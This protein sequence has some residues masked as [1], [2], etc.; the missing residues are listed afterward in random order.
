MAGQVVPASD[1]HY[2]EDRTALVSALKSQR[3]DVTSVYH[4]FNPYPWRLTADD[5]SQMKVLL[6]T[7]VRAMTATVQNYFQDPRLRQIMPLSD[8]AQSL[9]RLADK[10][11]YRTGGIRPDFLHATDGAIRI[12]E[13]NARFPLNG[14]FLSHAFDAAIRTAPY[15]RRF[16]IRWQGIPALAEVPE[17]L[18]EVIGSNRRLA[19]VKGQEHGYDM[20]L[21]LEFWTNSIELLPEGASSLAPV[22]DFVVM[23]LHQ[24]E[25][26]QKLPRDALQAMIDNGRYFNDVRT[27]L[28]GHDKRLLA[29]FTSD[30]LRDYLP[31]EDV[32]RLHRHVVCTYVVGLGGDPLRAALDKQNE[33]LVKPNLFGKGQ[34][35]V[36]GRN[37]SQQAWR[38]ELD[39][40]PAEYVLQPFVEQQKFNILTEVGDDLRSV[41]M[42]VVGLLPALN[43]HVLGPGIYRASLEDIVNVAGGGAILAPVIASNL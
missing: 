39:S 4:A 42:N 30:I 1:S 7:V 35:I 22:S 25:L 32:E 8:E 27:I 14:F 34:G 38:S 40:A 5:V 18:T 10:Y 23:E 31:S 12:N 36:I 16:P 11:P 9:L 19:V 3:P 33:W 15:Q 17:A 21:L 6:Q 28:V 43:E 26:L 24:H 2:Y 20:R 29:V 41:P 13:I 37:I